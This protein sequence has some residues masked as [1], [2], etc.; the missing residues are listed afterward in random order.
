MSN[1]IIVTLSH[2]KGFLINPVD[3]ENPSQSK[4]AKFKTFFIL[5]ICDLIIATI[6][7]LLVSVLNELNLI[8]NEENK[9]LD[10]LKIYPV[11]VCFL[12]FIIIIPLFEEVIFRLHLRFKNFYLLRLIL[13]ITEQFSKNKLEFKSKV[14]FNW[15]KHYKK[16]FYTTAVIFAL[17]HVTNY[18]FTIWVILFSPI[19]IFAQFAT[20]IFIGYLRVN[21]GFNWGYLLHIVHN[22]VFMGLPL[23]FINSETEVVNIKNQDYSLS[24]SENLFQ[25]SNT[26]VYINYT[27]DSIVING[28]RLD[29][30]IPMILE[31]D[32]QVVEF[33]K[34]SIYN[35]IL[36]MNF[37]SNL[38]DKNS[39]RDIILNKLKNQYKF[40]FETKMVMKDGWEMKIIDSIKFKRYANL[41]NNGGISTS[42]VNDDKIDITKC[43]LDEII[44]IL[45][46]HFNTI[47]ISHI[48]SNYLYTLNFKARDFETFRKIALDQFGL[49]FE[50]ISV[51]TEVTLV[52]S[53]K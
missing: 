20:G 1:S 22:F 29:K 15:T 33:S 8:N 27:L 18:H 34:D 14:I 7:I 46:S 13:L 30:I 53:L 39:N 49:G 50:K 40:D 2:L 38:K 37:N 10:F 11:I 36:K 21:F 25:S 48:N 12:L 5:L 3:E 31:K 41:I 52:K 28:I 17:I 9:I 24:I 43:G 45:N 35:K 47:I 32:Q 16:V 4:T 51:E 42:T 44:K 19:L 6:V 23:L 26:S